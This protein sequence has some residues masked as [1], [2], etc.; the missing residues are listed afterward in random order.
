M[1]GRSTPNVNR[2]C[3][4]RTQDVSV[5]RVIRARDA[6]Q[7]CRIDVQGV[8]EGRARRGSQFTPDI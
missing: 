4:R 7:T 6:C 3:Q 8:E 2:S 5:R 1:P